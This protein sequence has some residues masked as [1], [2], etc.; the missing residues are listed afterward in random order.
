MNLGLK[1]LVLIALIFAFENRLQAQRIAMIAPEHSSLTDRFADALSTSLVSNYRVVDLGLAESAYNSLHIDAPFNQT[2]ESAKRVCPVVGCDHYLLI[3]TSVDRRSSSKRPDYFEAAVCLFLVNGRTGLL[4]KFLIATKQEDNGPAAEQSLLK[5]I[6]ATANAIRSAISASAA[7]TQP[8][9]EMFDP[10]SK[11]MRP[12]MPYKRIK[13]EY[14]DTAYLFDIKATVDA[15]V[16]IDETGKVGKIEI[17]RWAG[18]GL[19]DSVIATV[20]K[21]NWRPGE[22][23]GK[24][25]PMRV[26]LRYNFTKIEKEPEQ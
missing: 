5:D 26:L 9:F 18:F 11:T 3:K 17:V 2:L 25:L 4:E 22:R 20:N 8:E 6:D 12:A 10:D 23:N 7:A 16:S 19:D 14:T 13:P 21:M 15:E 24:P 1:Y